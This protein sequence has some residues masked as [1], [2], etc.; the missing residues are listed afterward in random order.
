MRL[1]P[2]T[3]TSDLVIFG[4]TQ[5]HSV[6]AKAAL[7][8]GIEFQAIETR[9]EDGWG[10]RKE[11]LT[12]ALENAKRYGKVPFILREWIVSSVIGCMSSGV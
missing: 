10:L 2:N 11:G 8:L 7:I 9:E 12:K 6:G 1:F 4:T 3:N 5:T